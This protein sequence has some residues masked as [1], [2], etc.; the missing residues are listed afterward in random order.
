MW[1]TDPVP[2]HDP[3]LEDEYDDQAGEWEASTV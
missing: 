1:E 2:P 3:F